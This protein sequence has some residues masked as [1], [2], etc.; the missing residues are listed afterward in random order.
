M[1]SEYYIPLNHSSGKYKLAD[2]PSNDE[3]GLTLSHNKYDILSYSVPKHG[4]EVRL[5][6]ITEQMILDTLSASYDKDGQLEYIEITCGDMVKLVYI[7][8]A[9]EETAKETIWNFA[10]YHADKIADE[11]INRKQKLARLF[12]EYFYDGEAVDFSVKPATSADVQAVIDSYDGSL[13]AIDNCG[14]YPYKNRISCDNDTLKIMLSCTSPDFSD[15]L[16]G[17]A[18]YVMTNRIKD[19]VLDVIDK[20]KDFKLIAGMYD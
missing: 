18:V 13:D 10:N 5:Y 16:F 7:R 8:F 3:N 9:D 20:T 4:T 17:F 15:D 11:I 6:S 14:D 12:I 1:T 2:L 19:R